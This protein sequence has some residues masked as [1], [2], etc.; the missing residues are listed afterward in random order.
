MFGHR[1]GPGP[2]YPDLHEA[3]RRLSAERDGPGRRRAIQIFGTVAAAATFAN[4]RASE[5]NA[6]AYKSS[7][8]EL[9]LVGG[10]TT[11]S[12]LFA[13]SF[14]GEG[15]VN[16]Y[17][18]A[19]QTF[20]NSGRRIPT[21]DMV[22]DN[23]NGLDFGSMARVLK[24]A[25][26][27]RGFKYLVINGDSL[28]G[29]IGLGAA[30]EANIPVAGFIANSSPDKLTDTR[31]GAELTAAVVSTLDPQ[32]PAVQDAL[33]WAKDFWCYWRDN[34]FG[35]AVEGLWGELTNLPSQMA[36][37]GSPQL[38]E[39]QLVYG[40]SVS[41]A[42]LVP[43]LRRRGLISPLTTS[44]VFLRAAYDGVDDP[45]ASFAGWEAD[46]SSVGIPM[47][48]LS[49]GPGSSHADV[50]TERGPLQA[51]NFFDDLIRQFDRPSGVLA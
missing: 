17:W 8:T 10:K 42:S 7:G 46:F 40:E 43:A 39:S 31:V 44:T 16:D 3:D 5:W 11:K 9:Q 27:D 14:G 36:S 29:L 4:V 49:M 34:P 48:N 12:N 20:Q 21:A 1:K 35:S 47:R 24:K 41:A 45:D 15:N 6:E 51:D 22:Y 32:S 33:L 37:A 50:F 2:L 28:G 30:L 25:Q 18:G 26:Q 19:V 13:V 38:Q 23:I